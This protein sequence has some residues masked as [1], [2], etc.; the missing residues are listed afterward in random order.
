MHRIGLSLSGGGFRAT[1]YHLG[2][3]RF[4]R[5]AKILPKISHITT[6]SGGSVLG[7]HLALNWDK[8]NGSDAE[9]DQVAGEIVRF[10]QL[11]V[12]NRIVRRFPMASAVNMVR[13]LFRLRASRQLTRPGLLEKHYERF[14][15]G[16][17]SLFQLPDRPRLHILSTNLSEGCLCSFYQ[18]GLLLQRRRPGQRDRFEQVRLGLATVPMAVAA[19]SAFPGF[20]PPLELNGW[21]VGVEEGVFNRQAFT[22]GGVFDNLGLRMFRCLEQSWIRDIAPLGR[23]DFLELESVTTAL[24]SAESLPEGT[25]LRRLWEMLPSSSGDSSEAMVHGLWEVIRSEQLFC[26]PSFQGMELTDPS[27]QSLLVYV[28]ASGKQPDLSDRL[29]LNRQ[30]VESALQQVIG[31]PCLRAS[32][33]DFDGILV[34]DAGKAFKVDANARAGGLMRTALRTTDILMD[35]VYQLEHEA[36]ENS[37]GVLFFQMTDVVERSQDPDAPHPEIQRQAARIRT[38]LDRFTPLEISSLVQHGYC[39]ARQTCRDQALFNEDIPAGPPWDPLAPDEPEGDQEPSPAGSLS[40]ADRALPTAR[41]LRY[42]SVRRIWRTLFSFRDWPTYVWIALLALVTLSFPYQLYQA[43]QRARQQN[44]RARQQQILLTAIAKMSPDYSEILDLLESGPLPSP[45]PAAYA[46]VES[47]EPPDFAGFE[48]ISD[49]RIF[50]LRRWAEATDSSSAP[51]SHVRLRVRRTI[52]GSENTH[53]RFQASTVDDKLFMRFKTESL[54]PKLSRMQ[55]A[56]GSYLWEFDLDFSRIPIG[57]DTEVVLEGAIVTEMAEQVADEGHF[58]FTIFAETGLVQMWMLMPQ[59]REYDYFEIS[60]YPIGS[61][62]LAQIIEPDTR[63]EL[64][65]GAI[66]TFRL[67]NPK[68]DHRYECHW[69]WSQPSES[70]P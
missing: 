60:G 22:D 55:Q 24:A 2:V 43:N 14:L 56:D 27:A 50:D 6:V 1:L 68:A 51:T 31:K 52:E 41:D 8:Y 13:R 42:S 59:G 70:A 66:A 4:L 45:G 38:D 58:K 18:G 36:F 21:D 16:D 10:V 32:R 17:T 5:D 65:I 35:R 33:G 67:V 40:A 7:A 49:T 3:I 69:K 63:V 28:R 46:E 15:Y 34:S 48:V 25:P 30:I 37:P 23:D 26:D 54:R 12:R 39:V 19:S 11:D 47:I 20:F 29:W 62:E 57:T 64:P 61:P 9:F 44:Q 53:L